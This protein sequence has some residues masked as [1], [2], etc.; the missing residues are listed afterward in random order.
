MQ[1]RKTLPH[2]QRTKSGDVYKGSGRSV[3]GVDIRKYVAMCS[4]LLIKFGG[5][6]MACGMTLDSKNVQVNV[7][8]IRE[9]TIPKIPSSQ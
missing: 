3:K 1:Y 9:A 7:S 6:T 5:H 2:P 8:V 4:D